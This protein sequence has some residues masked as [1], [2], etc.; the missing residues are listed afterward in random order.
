MRF[1]LTALLTT[2]LIGC[3]T[4]K[5]IPNDYSGPIATI[6]DSGFSE[7]STKA[8]LFVL[9][10]ID[11][12]KIPTS[13][14]ASA[15]ANAGQGFKLRTNFVTRDVPAKPMKVKLLA[16]HSTGA[17]IHAMFSQAIGT[18]FT[19]EGIVEFNP[20]PNGKYI[21]KGELKKEGSSVWIEDAS[22]NQAVTEKVIQTKK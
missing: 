13:V 6:A 19:V 22:T 21:V 8:Q 5:P 1:L 15:G 16:T 11:G 12:N 10:E 2:L 4:H 18:F 20:Q 14:G 9:S 7:G 3:A 17:P